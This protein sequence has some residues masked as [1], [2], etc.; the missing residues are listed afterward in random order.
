MFHM[1]SH[2]VQYMN[3]RPAYAGTQA[4]RRAVL[5][6]KTLGRDEGEPTLAELVRAVGLNKTTTFRLLTA[7]EAEGLVERGAL[8]G[9]RLGPELAA[10]GS[11]ALG[12]SDL[13]EAA[14]P[15]L[16]ALARATRETAHLEVRVGA[17]TL[18]LDEA[19]GGHRVGTTPSVGTRWP[20]HATSTGKVLLAALATDDLAG[21]LDSPLPALTPR[22]ITDP[23]A[24]ER[25]LARVRERGYATGIEELEPG[26]MA[27]AVPVRA[28]DGQVVAALGVGGPRVRLDAARLEAIA[29]TLP[30]HAARVSERLGA[31]PISPAAGS[32]PSP[33]RTHRAAARHTASPTQRKRERR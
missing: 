2:M 15:E 28:R 10:L 6:L 4:V 21:F 13:R 19:A 9:Y 1:A 14:R 24:L 27:V 3:P 16:L 25:E 12:A 23:R 17:E 11:R 18:I 7:L 5:L 31:R 26:F 32:R 20:A 33:D 29:A 22:T 30:A 8:D